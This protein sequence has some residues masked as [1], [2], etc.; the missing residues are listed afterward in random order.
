M[1]DADRAR[2]A[3]E[4]GSWIPNDAVVDI[5]GGVGHWKKGSD[6]L[7][8]IGGSGLYDIPELE[9]LERRAVST[10][11]GSPSDA[12]I[13]GRIGGNDVVFLARH[14]AGHRFTPTELP[15]QANIYAL[16]ALGVTHLLTI[17]AVGSLREHL[18]PLTIVQ[19]DQII[20][21]TVGRP[22]SF[23]G[24]G[25]V[26]HVGIAEPY[27][28]VFGQAVAAAS[29]R[30]GRS[31]VRGGTYLCIEGPQFSTRAESMLFRSWGCSVIGMT[32]MP[33]ARL[34][35]E[36]ELCYSTLAMVTDFDVWHETE[37]AVHVDL[38]REYLHLNTA[39]ARE[40]VV[41]IVTNGSLPERSCPCRDALASAIIT[42]PDAISLETRERLGII[43]GRYLPGATD[44]Q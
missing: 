27:C 1:V 35:R 32:A 24:E 3:V 6:V 9:V 39:A 37:D 12:L 10:P 20:D 13:L 18:P 44:Q 21:R 16:K 2:V 14:G 25:V 42:A 17:S 15:Y 22:R 4:R 43:A 31:V 29:A 28:D 5:L 30:A 33:E 41:E 36:G 7:G 34:A 40:I 38:V 23:F 11:Y 19:P 8:I 26:A